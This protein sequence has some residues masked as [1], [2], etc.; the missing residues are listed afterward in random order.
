MVDSK[1]FVWSVL[2]TDVDFGPD[3]ALYFCDWV[4]GWDKPNKGRIYRVLDESRRGDPGVREVKELLAEGMERRGLDEL[5]RLLSHPDM[6]V[7]QEAQFELA[8]RGG[9]AWQT[10]ATVARSKAGTLARIHA[11]WGLGQAARAAPQ[12]T[13]SR[14][15]SSV[16]VPLLAD[17]DPEVRAQAAKVLGEARDEVAFAGLVKLLA[18]PSPRVRFFAAIALGKLGRPQAVEPLL[19]MLRAAGETRS[20][21]PPRGGDGPGRLGQDRGVDESDP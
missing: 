18:D 9:A 10:L 6:R 3:G 2:A 16:L 4:E 11:V 8:A 7:R 21:P 20:V 19:A 15:E 5:A 14:E 12:T 1:Q 17:A 13:A